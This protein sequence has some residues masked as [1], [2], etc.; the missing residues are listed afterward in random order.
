MGKE[1][2]RARGAISGMAGSEDLG[3]P[4]AGQDTNDARK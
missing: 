3:V 1:W 4:G 2:T